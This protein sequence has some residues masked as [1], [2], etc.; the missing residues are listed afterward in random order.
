MITILSQDFEVVSKIESNNKIEKYLHID[1]HP[2]SE[3]LYT[4]GYFETLNAID[5]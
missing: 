3:L 5:S 2:V 1:F 4:C